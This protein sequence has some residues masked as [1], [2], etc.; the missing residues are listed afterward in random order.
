MLDVTDSII[1][2]DLHTESFP[3]G[4]Q[5]WSAITT[6]KFGMNWDTVPRYD[7]VLDQ[8]FIETE[9]G[10]LF[11]FDMDS[12]QP[13]KEKS[14]KKPVWSNSDNWVLDL[15]NKNL[16]G[17]KFWGVDTGYRGVYDSGYGNDYGYFITSHY[18]QLAEVID[19][20]GEDWME[21]ILADKAGDWDTYIKGDSYLCNTQYARLPNGRWFDFGT[22]YFKEYITPVL[23]FYELANCEYTPPAVLYGYFKL[24]IVYY[25]LNMWYWK[26][27]DFK[28]YE[29]FKKIEAALES[30]DYL[31]AIGSNINLNQWMNFITNFGTLKQNIHKQNGYYGDVGIPQFND[32][33][34]SKM[35]MGLAQY[36]LDY[37][38]PFEQ[39]VNPMYVYTSDEQGNFYMAS[40]KSLAHLK[41]PFNK[42]DSP[43]G[44][45]LQA[46]SDPQAQLVMDANS[47]MYALRG[48]LYMVG[49]NGIA[50]YK[51]PTT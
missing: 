27:S 20:F 28:Y 10:Y 16:V 9:N 49:S 39:L 40:A 46:F 50:V 47:K 37:P 8:L 15:I 25:R 7:P 43:T 12:K 11:A 38:K 3:K 14:I 13:V 30:S 21:E 45:Y 36:Q 29:V 17:K 23:D 44:D 33:P 35:Y 51:I 5:T 32:T 31:K 24:L 48:Y 26:N 19:Q 2:Y 42:V 18:P 34:F 1:Q 6:G 41:I 4:I 22:Y